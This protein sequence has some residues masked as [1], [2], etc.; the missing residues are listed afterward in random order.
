[1]ITIQN[2][3][4]APTL[5]QRNEIRILCKKGQSNNFFDSRIQAPLQ[6]LTLVTMAIKDIPSAPH[7]G[8]MKAATHLTS[9]SLRDAIK[10]LLRGISIGLRSLV[11][12][13][14]IS[15]AVTFGILYPSF[16]YR[17]LE[18]LNAV[19]PTFEEQIRTLQNKLRTLKNQKKNKFHIST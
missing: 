15:A 2:F 18:K 3:F 9:F 5:E 12:V 11:Q 6:A 13:A 10:E 1:M 4:I 14:V 17:N 7:N 19:D 16:V 8:L